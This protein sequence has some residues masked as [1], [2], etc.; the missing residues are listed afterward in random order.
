[1]AIIYSPINAVIKRSQTGRILALRGEDQIDIVYIWGYND[2]YPI[3]EIKNASY[4]DVI[5]K[6]SES[7]LEQ[8]SLR[9]VPDNSDWE[10]VNNLR[11]S[12]PNAFVTIYTYAPFV[13]VSSICGPDLRTVFYEYDSFGQLSRIYKKE[14]GEDIT[15]ESYKYHYHTN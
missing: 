2:Q 8:I 15:I 11:T 13:G 12:L 14:N 4:Y 9:T 3:A 7:R 10:S 1:M 5:S 6:I